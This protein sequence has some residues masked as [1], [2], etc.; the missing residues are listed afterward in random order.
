MPQNVAIEI[1][2]YIGHLFEVKDNQRIFSNTK[3]YFESRIK[4]GA[5]K[6]GLEQ[7]RVHDLRHSHVSLLINMGFTV[8]D[9]A[10]R[11]GHKSIYITFK[12]A[13]MFP[14]TQKEMADRLNEEI[15]RSREDGEEI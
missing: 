12:Y 8:V 7:I 9:I 4:K 13:H 14:T 10:K 6:A 3:Y 2:E 1:Q 11:V 5:K 15:E